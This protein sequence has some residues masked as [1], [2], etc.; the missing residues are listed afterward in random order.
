MGQER[1][2]SEVLTQRHQ[3]EASVSRKAEIPTKGKEHTYTVYRNKETR[4]YRDYF[5][6][7]FHLHMRVC[8][9]DRRLM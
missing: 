9:C 8:P 7:T 5:W 1:S 2:S 6:V 4:L 3:S